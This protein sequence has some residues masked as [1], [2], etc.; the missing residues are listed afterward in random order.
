[1]KEGKKSFFREVKQ[2][3]KNVSWPSK[4][5][6]ISSTGVVIFYVLVISL[7]LGLADYSILKLMNLILGIKG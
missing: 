1:M 7:F 4:E 2:E 3:Y 6:V 5:Q